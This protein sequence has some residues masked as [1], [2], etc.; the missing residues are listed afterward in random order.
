MPLQDLSILQIHGTLEALTQATLILV[1]GI[2]I[3]ASNL[4]IIASFINYRGPQE[5]INI[6]LLSLACADLLCGL[7]IVPL[8]IYPALSGQWV[9]GDIICRLTGYLEV[10]LW[11]ITVYTFMWISVDRYLAVRKPLRYETVQTRT[12]YEAKTLP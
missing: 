4:L 7:L 5:V 1:L 11:S 2:A 12:R 8:S 3:V 9:Y 6:Y 10:T